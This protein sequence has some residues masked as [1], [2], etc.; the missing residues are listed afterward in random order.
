MSAR[1]P[2]PSQQSE[3]ADQRADEAAADARDAPA[4]DDSPADASDGSAVGDAKDL[5]SQIDRLNDRV[6]R[7]QAELDNVQKRASRELAE[8]R[9]YAALPV[10]RD[11]LPAVDNIE[12]AVSAAEGAADGQSL[13]EGFKLVAQQ[14]QAVLAQYH[15]T[16]IEALGEPFDPN[17]HEAIGQ[18]PSEEHPPGTV[19]MVVQ[20]G[21]RLHD[22]V[23]RPAR[24]MIASGGE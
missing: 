11:L 7:L 19:M 23:V 9:R 3:T 20:D 10:V 1:K 6:L 18:Q 13:L 24:V 16:K 17:V 2:G 5:Q 21:Y 8:E 12:R 14:I 15:C 22:R 4:G